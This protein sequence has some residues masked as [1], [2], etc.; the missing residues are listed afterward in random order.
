LSVLLI[1]QTKK[2]F[3]AR[4]LAKRLEVSE[5]TIYRDFEALSA[6]GVPVYAEAGPSGGYALLDSYQTNLTGLTPAEAQAMATFTAPASLA[7]IGL[8]QSFRT[9]LIKLAAALPTMQQLA[10]EHIRQ[11][12]HIDTTRWFHIKEDLPHLPLLRDAVWQDRQI[13]VGYHRKDGSLTEVMVDPYALVAKVGVWYLVTDT[14]RGMRVFRASRLETVELLETTFQRPAEFDL[15]AFWEAWC[16]EFET[17]LPRYWVTLR[18]STA[19]LP[20]LI[21]TQGEQGREV[22]NQTPSAADGWKVVTLDFEK[23]AYALA[24]LFGLAPAVEVLEPPELRTYFI[25][26]ADE[27]KRLYGSIN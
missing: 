3:K 2:K 18:V 1:L 7:D 21:E 19:A 15:A 20:A 6:M 23:K 10:A 26:V 16:Q 22:L 9:G 8:S 27:I 25:E 24:H 5:R 14:P 4:E 13:R 12:L 11:R 17:R